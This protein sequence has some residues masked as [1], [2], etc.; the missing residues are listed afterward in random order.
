M[1]KPHSRYSGAVPMPLKLL[2]EAITATTE[3]S[4][5]MEILSAPGNRAN[6]VCATTRPA[7]VASRIV[8]VVALIIPEAGRTPASPREPTVGSHDIASHSH[9][10]PPPTRLEDPRGGYE[11]VST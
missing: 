1:V 10:A 6:G 4:S 2:C 11:Y 7:R 8:Q 9:P 3:I 5:A